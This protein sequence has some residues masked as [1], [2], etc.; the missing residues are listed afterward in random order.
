MKLTYNV[1]C[2]DDRIDSLKDTKQYLT[3]VNDNVGIET[4]YY[5][6]PVVPTPTEKP[7]DFWE[8]IVSQ[9]E[10]AFI[11]DEVYD[12]ILVDLHMPLDVSG[13]DVIQCIRESHSIYRPIIFYSAGE[14]A[15]DEQAV[16]DLHKAVGDADLSGKS[17]FLTPRSGL[18]KK[19]TQIFEQM[20]KEEH[21]IN[22]VRG[23][24]MDRVS[25]LDASIVE[26]VQNEKLLELVPKGAVRNK[27]LTDFK[28]YLKE[29]LDKA[30]E[31]YKEIN[32]LDI[33]AIPK[34]LKDNQKKVSTYRKGYLLKEMLKKIDGLKA[35]A[36]TLSEGIDG[37]TSLRILRNE[38]GH[39]TAEQLGDTHTDDK[40]THIR[41]EARRQLKNIEDIREKL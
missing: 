10:G 7:E 14:P 17:I 23:L 37:D 16:Q 22:R 38:Y 1:L 30:E 34:F 24:L 31:S 40:C 25:E 36:D 21:K 20:H 18:T 19:A 4:K 9:I 26:L 39:T 27:I 8:R 35:C 13:S 3:G 6:I 41:K 32:R 33:T 5:D 29:D 28:K 11:P 2:I 12:L 15:L